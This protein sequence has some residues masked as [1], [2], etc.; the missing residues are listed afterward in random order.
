M[1]ALPADAGEAVVCKAISPFLMI[2]ALR[3]TK[4]TILTA[5]LHPWICLGPTIGSAKAPL[6]APVGTDR[7]LFSKKL[8]FVIGTFKLRILWFRHITAVESFI[9]LLLFFSCAL[10]ADNAN[11]C[12]PGLIIFV[13]A[14]IFFS[15]EESKKAGIL[16][17]SRAA[18]AQNNAIK[19]ANEKLE[20]ASRLLRQ[21]EDSLVEMYTK[22]LDEDH[23]ELELDTQQV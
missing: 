11:K 17:Q 13:S 4:L 5:L 14:F 22:W 10:R 19:S 23:N 8:L 2:P 20:E 7:V 12:Q 9:Y 21:E 16:Q 3:R 1:Q 18:L 15:V 6:V